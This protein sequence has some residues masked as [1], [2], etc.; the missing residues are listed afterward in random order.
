MQGCWIFRRQHPLTDNFTILRFYDS[1]SNKKLSYRSAL[2]AYMEGAR[3][4]SAL[5]AA[6]SGYTYAYGQIRNPQQM[7]V[8]RAVRKAHFT[9]N[10]LECPIHLKVRFKMNRAFI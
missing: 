1:E 2:A 5:P 7:Y 4:S 9:M 6:P 8:K 10:D 3:P